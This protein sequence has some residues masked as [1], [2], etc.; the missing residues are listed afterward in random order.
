MRWLGESS[1]RASALGVVADE[2][3]DPG[4]AV[5]GDPVE[6]VGEDDVGARGDAV[7]DYEVAVHPFEQRPHGRDPD[8]ARDQE[9]LGR[10]AAWPGEDPEGA[11]GDD[12]RADRDRPES[13]GV[14]AEALDGD[15]ERVA[16]GRLRERERVLRLPEA[17]REEAPEEELTGLG[18]EPVEPRPPIRSETTPGALLR[19][20]GDPEVE[21]CGPCQWSAMR[22]KSTSRVRV[23]R[24]RASSRRR[25]GR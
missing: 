11:L 23:R 6:F 25:Y 5:G 7:E 19:H 20:L 8:P 9:G 22:K 4:S 16:A 12:A 10:R 3:L 15:P 24:G 17:S 2:V 1:S 18:A 14:V 21:A 13:R